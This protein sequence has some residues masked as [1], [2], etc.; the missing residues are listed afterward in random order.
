MKLSDAMVLGATITKLRA[1]CLDH[2]ALGAAANAVGIERA[3]LSSGQ[4]YEN[5]RWVAIEQYWPWLKKQSHIDLGGWTV[6]TYW[7]QVADTFN[8]EVA[9]TGRMTF[10]QL[11]DYVRYVEPECGKCNQFTCTCEKQQPA[12][13]EEKDLLC[14]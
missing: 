2:C 10:D 5:G 3:W 4:S 6:Q 1:F 13:V 12:A 14:A 8:E 7:S 9:T 11:V